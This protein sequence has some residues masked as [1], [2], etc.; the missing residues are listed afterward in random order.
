MAGCLQLQLPHTR[1][2]M[3]Q[4]LA[5]PSRSAPGQQ[6]GVPHTWPKQSPLCSCPSAPAGRLKASGLGLWDEHHSGAPSAKRPDLANLPQTNQLTVL[7]TQVFIQQATC[8]S[9][10]I[11]AQAAVC[12]LTGT[13]GV[14]GVIEMIQEGGGNFPA[15]EN[16]AD[17]KPLAQT[18]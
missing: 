17:N 10:K 8:V 3:V 13:A 1:N 11:M 9:R 15:R 18:H 2:C 7:W 6:S 12:V 4:V 14:T 16:E 5:H